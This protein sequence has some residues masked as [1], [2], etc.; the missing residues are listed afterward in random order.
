MGVR[1]SY[2]LSKIIALI[3]R[4]FSVYDMKNVLCFVES[5]NFYDLFNLIMRSTLLT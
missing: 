4:M 3:S 2:D 1:K 5:E